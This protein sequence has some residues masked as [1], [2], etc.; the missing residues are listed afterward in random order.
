MFGPL[1]AR[2]GLSFD[3]LRALV[4]VAEAGGIAR[5]VGKD[6]T[7]QSLVSRQLKELE[8][9]FEI[10]LTRR[11]G[12]GLV[13]TAAGERLASLARAH[14][15]ALAD[16]TEGS[17]E[18]APTFHLGAGDSLLH[19]RVLPRLGAVRAV[20]PH[21]TLRVATAGP[22]AIVRSLRELTLDFGLLRGDATR[23]LASESLGRV[24]YAVYVPRR[25]LGAR[26]RADAAW[27]LATLPLAV[28]SGDE[29][30]TAWLEG[31]VTQR[32][33]APRID[34]ACVTFPQACRAVASGQV[35]AILPTLAR[36]ELGRKAVAELRSPLLAE[37]GADIHLV[38]NARLMRLRSTADVA[39]RAFVKAFRAPG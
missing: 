9:F 34:L 20:L 5:A 15:L 3:R 2:A 19:W 29:L 8:E 14:L 26:R 22:D 18:L 13:L 33:I 1:F 10:E 23:E 38:W 39:R 16:F 6:P 25:L 7:R 30:F 24:E 4:E 27:V 21:A 35:A 17:R 32:G 36:G 31:I 11:A 37:L 12:R 28:P